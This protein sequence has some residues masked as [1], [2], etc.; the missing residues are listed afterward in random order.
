MHQATQAAQAVEATAARIDEL[1]TNH[2]RDAKRSRKQRIIHLVLSPWARSADLDLIDEV[3]AIAAGGSDLITPVVYALRAQDPANIDLTNLAY[4]ALHHPQRTTR[5]MAVEICLQAM[6]I[7][8][9]RKGSTSIRDSIE[10]VLLV[11]IVGG[12]LLAMVLLH[13]YG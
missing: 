11:L 9:L 5:K 8:K 13:I 4:I 1:C 10:T 12:V 3:K 7:A 2:E 6:F